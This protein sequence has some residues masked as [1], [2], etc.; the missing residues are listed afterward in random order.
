MELY[1][2]FRSVRLVLLVVLGGIFLS[3]AAGKPLS[4]RL[5]LLVLGVLVAAV[6][7][8]PNFG[9]FHA[10]HY[11]H[12]HY[13]DAFHYFMGA[14]YLPELGY[15]GL[16]EATFVA[17]R[18]LGAFDYV[19]HVRD[20]MGY[21]LRGV[22]TI[23]AKRVRARFS[24]D[25]W[26]AF[27][28]DLNFFGPHIREWRGLFVD[29]G[30]NDPP[31]RAV[32]LHLLVRWLPANAFT[33]TLLTS[34]DYL[35]IIIAFAF[36]RRAFGE[37]PTA[38]TLAFFALSFFARF[39]F[40][41]GSV[42]RWDWIAALLG[43]VAAFARGAGTTA[44]LL[45]GYAAVARIFPLL[46]VIPLG[47]KW[48]QSRVARTRDD[49]LER[50]LRAALGLVLVVAVSVA[51]WG[52]RSPHVPEFAAK[53]WAHS[54]TPFINN[55]GLGSLIVYHSAPWHLDAEGHV[56]V[57]H[58]AAKAARPAPYVLPLVSMLYLLAALPLIRRAGPLESVMYAVPL[59]FY[60]LSPTGYY[61]SFLVLLVL[62]PWRSERTD[63]VRLIE[64]AVLTFIMAAGYA[65]ELMSDELLPLF[66]MAS[67]QMG[68]FFLLW[69]GFEYA[70][71]SP[72]GVRLTAVDAPLESTRPGHNEPAPRGAGD[73]QPEARA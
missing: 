13:W 22:D 23:D 67:I 18:D 16:Y 54:Q 52:A 1:Q 14:K 31:S 20:L 45:L 62:L 40:I 12:I 56:Y 25:R 73:V 21:G 27:Q 4:R 38:L 53:I 46:F 66:Y 63:G 26:L 33:L 5:R 35:A 41:G 7:S 49:T 6:L 61:Y 24:S 36:V 17:G 2:G 50:C 37:M 60:A 28:R 51:L 44:G 57:E 72:Q 42:L 10:N 11:D 70:R 65:F 47:I 68:L 55:V 48:V 34:L 71:L 64:M 39:D 29:Q 69:L 59:V 3:L 58:E 15:S 30:Y 9:V 8:Y 32:L 19:T 43:G